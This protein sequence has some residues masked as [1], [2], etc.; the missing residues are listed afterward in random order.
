MKFDPPASIL[1]VDPIERKKFLEGWFQALG[2]VLTAVKGKF[3]KQGIYEDLLDSR[4][5]MYSDHVEE[6]VLLWE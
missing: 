1:P 6:G 3:S 2:V 5:K 4:Q